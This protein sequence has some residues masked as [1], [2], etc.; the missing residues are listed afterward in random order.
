MIYTPRKEPA[1]IL[2][3]FHV[4]D[5]IFAIGVQER[6]V[7]LYNQQVR[8]HNLIWALVDLDRAKVR[9]LGRVAVI[10]GGAA[11]LTATAALL[12]CTKDTSV[13]LFEKEWDLCPVQQ[14][15]DGRW[16]HPSLYAWPGWGS[17]APSASLPILNWSEGRASDVART[18]LDGFSK[19]CQEF[20][21]GRFRGFVGVHHLQVNAA[22]KDIRFI[23]TNVVLNGPYFSQGE[24]EGRTDRFDTI[25]FAAGFGWER[26]NQFN[27]NSYWRNEQIG[28]PNL[29]VDR[30]RYLVSGS[31]D[32][33]LI[34]VCRLTIERFR[35]DTILYEL[36]CD[37]LESTERR[38][39]DDLASRREEGLLP[40]F[41][42]IETTLLKRPMQSLRH[43]LRKDTAVTLH[44][45]GVDASK[46]N[47]LQDIFG[48]TSSVL[49]RV[50]I[51]LL[52]RCGAISIS[53]RPLQEAIS[54]AHISDNHVLCRHGC[55]TGRHLELI[56]DDYHQVKPMF[57]EMKTKQ[58]QH[59]DRY[60]SPG[61]FPVC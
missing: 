19:N 58:A 33:A 53:R 29:S 45:A 23:G 25:I 40:Y 44:I 10:G 34:D 6:G 4:S 1:E 49:N 8:A 60:W 15:C 36:F 38:L 46:P 7:T 42:Q 14:G 17:R 56:F 37:E 35:Q 54:S 48:P 50:L 11:G 52:Y 26:T 2:Q 51:Y 20:A 21:R 30:T 61:Y 47:D 59:P 5:G 16:L 28:Q 3:T 41:E 43:R 27:T 24:S 57:A 9:K 32:G 55:D 12:A 22:H 18:L 31:G 39:R 13:T